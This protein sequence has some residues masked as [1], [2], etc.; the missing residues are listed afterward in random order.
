MSTNFYV[1][2]DP[3]C[4]NPDHIETLHI[5][6]RSGGWRFSFHGV[7]KKGLV[8]WGVWQAFLA[9]RT[10]EDEYGQ[11]MT[12]A[13]FISMVDGWNIGKPGSPHD[14]PDPNRYHDDE[15]ND[16]YNGEFF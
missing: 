1:Q 11:K 13:E 4:G 14:H 16:F 2:D 15:G 10:V 8:S 12:A 6:K 9:G 7:P 5:G 3:T